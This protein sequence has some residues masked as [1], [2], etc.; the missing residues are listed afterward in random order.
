MVWFK[1]EGSGMV[2]YGQGLYGIVRYDM[3]G[4]EGGRV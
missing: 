4:K 1:K 2:R 3:V